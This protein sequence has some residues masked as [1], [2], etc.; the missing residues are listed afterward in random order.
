MARPSTCPITPFNPNQSPCSYDCLGDGW[1]LHSLDGRYV[2]VGD[3]GDVIATSTRTTVGNLPALYNSRTMIEVDLLNGEP[4]ATTT[5]Q[6]MGHV[7]SGAVPTSAFAT[8]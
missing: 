1:L 6:G 3:S 8:P 7:V 4:T 2:F 5:R